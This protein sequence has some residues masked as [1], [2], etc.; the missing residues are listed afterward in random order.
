VTLRAGGYSYLPA[1]HVHR[2]RCEGTCA[3]F[4]SSDAKY[5]IHYVD[6]QGKEISPDQALK[7][8]NETVATR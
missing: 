6:P 2:F 4:V 1:H 5:D 7:P 3:L 8:I